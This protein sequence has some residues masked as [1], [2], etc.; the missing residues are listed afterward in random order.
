MNTD[1]NRVDTS[2]G[3]LFP[4]FQVHWTTTASLPQNRS[5][6]GDLVAA[7]G[8]GEVGIVLALEA[9]RLATFLGM[10]GYAFRKRY[11]YRDALGWTQLVFEA[12]HC[13][14]LDPESGRCGVYEARPTQCRTYPFWRSLV[15]DG[16]WHEEAGIYCEGVGKG[17]EYSRAEVDALMS[18]QERADEE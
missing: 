16:S 12:E 10:S 8:R 18:A 4:G 3:T 9:A 1:H 14:F 5:A 6:F 17:R 11:T 7:V 13:I 2:R 15:V